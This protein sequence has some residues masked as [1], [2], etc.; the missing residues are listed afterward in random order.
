MHVLTSLYCFVCFCV[1]VFLLS[2]GCPPFRSVLLHVWYW[3]VWRRSL[4]LSLRQRTVWQQRLRPCVGHRPLHHA[5]PVC[6][7]WLP[8]LLSHVIFLF[9]FSRVYMFLVFLCNTKDTK[10]HGEPLAGRC[11]GLGSTCSEGNWPGRSR[12]PKACLNGSFWSWNLRVSGRVVLDVLFQREPLHWLMAM[13]LTKCLN[14]QCND[15][16]FIL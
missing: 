9:S 8:G 7:S 10:V 5:V 14:S 11:H 2:C 13:I 6:G 4:S 1:C 3:L 12:A 16:C 15:A